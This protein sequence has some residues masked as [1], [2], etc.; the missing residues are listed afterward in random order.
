M[1]TK[2]SARSA[3]G[4]Q[5]LAGAALLIV[6]LAGFGSSPAL[7]VQV[8]QAPSAAPP[9]GDAVPFDS[10]FRMEALAPGV[11][12]AVV[13]SAPD[14]YAFAN[15]L[16]VVGAEGV[17]VVDTQQSPAAA[18]AL[19]RKIEVRTGLPV[20]WVVNTHWHGDHVYGNQVYRTRWPDVRFIGHAT[21][22]PDLHG[23]GHLRLDEARARLPERIAELRRILA[24]DTRPDDTPLT[25]EERDRVHRRLQLNEA[26]R[27]RLETV[28]LI[29]PTVTFTRRL[30][31]DLGGR[32]VVVRHFGPAHTRGD[33]VVHLP[34]EGIVAVG[35]LVEQGLPFVDDADPR[36]WKAAL[37][38]VS[39]LGADVVVPSHGSVRR[40]GS[41]LE[42]E[43]ALFQALVRYAEEGSLGPASGPAGRGLAR[44]VGS[45]PPAA[46]P[47]DTADMI[48]A[49]SFDDWGAMGVDPSED[50]AR[51]VRWL[52]VATKRMKAAGSR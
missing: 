46:G 41:L 29:S 44:E 10:V 42:A 26:Y 4:S 25:E 24:R 19:A 13:K 8:E 3:R 40:D 30:E 1:T 51:I 28:E 32:H 47:S 15:S 37:D 45:D 5:G 21:L 18:D 11:W 52:D 39:A 20:R 38:S 48:S 23:V 33:V 9:P 2:T 50:R 35:D 43:R 34:G 12:A 36:G 49:L 22:R 7:G 14:A 16:V 27:R 6:M 31:L 17:L